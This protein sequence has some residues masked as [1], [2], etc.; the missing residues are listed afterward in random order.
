MPN[1]D[2]QWDR[3]VAR[4]LGELS[5]GLKRQDTTSRDRFEETA[6]QHIEIR[7][8]IEAIREDI[9]AL[10]VK[11]DGPIADVADLKRFR[12]SVIGWATAAASG[13]TGVVSFV[14]PYVGKIF[15]IVK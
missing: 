4:A 1:G 3:E 14:A 10:D 6:R 12:R 15:G 5:E 7:Q 11:I 2:I 13:A 9:K 8:H